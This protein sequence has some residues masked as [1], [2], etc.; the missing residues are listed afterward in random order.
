M[1]GPKMYTLSQFC[2]SVMIDAP[3]PAEKNM[4]FTHGT[5]TLQ[6]SEQECGKGNYQKKKKNI[7]LLDRLCVYMRVLLMTL[8]GT[9]FLE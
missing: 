7:Q 9:L 1:S 8:Y 6:T 3:G 2:Y 5:L 4:L